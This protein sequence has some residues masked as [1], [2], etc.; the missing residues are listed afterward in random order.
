MYHYTV[1]RSSEVHEVRDWIVK[2]HGGTERF[3]GS[4]RKSFLPAAVPVTKW[5]HTADKIKIK[6]RMKK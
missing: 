5:W 3:F 2:L 6:L 4:G 1:A